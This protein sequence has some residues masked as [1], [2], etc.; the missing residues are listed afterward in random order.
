MNKKKKFKEIIRCVEEN[1]GTTKVLKRSS[2]FPMMK[3]EEK[4]N[5]YFSEQISQCDNE[6]IDS[7]HE[8]LNDCEQKNR[9]S[10]N[11]RNRRRG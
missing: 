10:R 2:S 6:G 4:Y 8:T 1:E 9:T 3:S 11:L 5:Y 7:E